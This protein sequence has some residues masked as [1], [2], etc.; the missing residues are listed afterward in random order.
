MKKA[1]RILAAVPAAALVLAAVPLTY[2]GL[3]MLLAEIVL[4]RSGSTWPIMLILAGPAALLTGFL[5]LS[6]LFPARFR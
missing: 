3:A 1:L 6:V 5:G 4:V 2:Y